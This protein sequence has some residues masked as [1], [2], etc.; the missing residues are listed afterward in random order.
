MDK[1]ETEPAS[2]DVD[3]G[4]ESVQRVYRD[5]WRNLRKLQGKGSKNS[6]LM[7]ALGMLVADLC[8][9]APDP[10]PVRAVFDQVVD[11]ALDRIE[12]RRTA[13]QAFVADGQ[14]RPPQ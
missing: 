14:A 3:F 1:P 10:A 11:C 7:T 9:S 13:N 4:A 2:I 6:D 12:Y 5:L 8:Y